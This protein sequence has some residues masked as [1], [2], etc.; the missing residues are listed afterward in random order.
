VS[1]EAQAAVE[2]EMIADR[3]EAAY[4]PF[5]IV[6]QNGMN[7]V[8]FDELFSAIVADVAQGV[9]QA[10]ISAKFHNTMAQVV[11]EM[12]QHLAVQAG[13]NKVALSGGVF[14]NRL[15]FRLTVAALEGVGLDV[16]THSEIPANDGGIS[17]GQAVIANFA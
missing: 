14:Q 10:T 6:E 11:V 13:I 3:N 17:V 15:L 4:Y 5:N 9:P 12:C 8:H 2:L 7:V 1:Y 16:L